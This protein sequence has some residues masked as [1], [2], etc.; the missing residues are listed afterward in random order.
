[1]WA[2][3]REQPTDPGAQRAGQCEAHDPWQPLSRE[4]GYSEAAEVT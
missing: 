4:A 1:M 3:L 2:G